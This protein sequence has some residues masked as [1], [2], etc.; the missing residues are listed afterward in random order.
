MKTINI[1]DRIINEKSRPFIVAEAGVNHENDMALARRL[2]DEA[3]LG[4]ADAIKFQTYKAERIAVKDSPT[5]WDA[6]ET[7]RDYFQKYDKFGE[8]DYRELAKYAEIKGIIF[9]ST[10][11]DFE[12]V[13]L[14][15]DLVQIFKIS[16]S[17]ITNIPFM[18]Y[19]AKKGKPIFLSTGA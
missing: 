10:P 4:K 18:R 1:R 15:D 5:Y 14:L 16:S 2:I 8:D 6:S 3:V 19:I 9:M 17:D 13:D 11:F 7:Q 12:A